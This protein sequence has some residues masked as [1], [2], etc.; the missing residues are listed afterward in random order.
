MSIDVS[1]YFYA[2]LGLLVLGSIYLII[3]GYK[4][5]KL[6][7]DSIVGQLV[8]TLVVV[9]IIQLYSLGIVCFAFL[10]FYAKGIWVLFPI[11]ILWLICLLFA[12]LAVRLAK[13]QV[14]NLVK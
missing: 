4:V 6:F 1:N 2:A 14:T 10:T 12:I 13:K 5:H 11:V 3:E 9:L 7:A 8:K